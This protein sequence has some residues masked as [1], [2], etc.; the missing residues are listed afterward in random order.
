MI[1][2]LLSSISAQE[3]SQVRENFAALG[4]KPTEVK[5]QGGHYLVGLENGQESEERLRNMPGVKKVHRVGESYQLVSRKWKQHPT[6]IEVGSDLLI[7]AD[8]LTVIAGPCAIESEEQI[9]STLKHLKQNGVSLMRGGVF[10]PRTS[11]YSFRG[12]GLEGLELWSA[13]ARKEGIRVVSEVLSPDQ[14]ELMLPYVDMFQVGARNSQ[15]FSLLHELG[16]VDRPVL[17]KRGLSGTLDELL[18]SAEYVFSGGNEKIILCERGIRTYETSYRNTL[19]LNAIPVLKE[20]THLPVFVD[21]SHGIGI[22]RHIEAVALAAVMAGADGLMYEVHESPDQAL[23]DAQQT[24][25]FDES[26][27]MLSRIRAAAQLRDTWR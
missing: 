16:R 21:P 26:K 20:K 4:L 3:L 9:R 12:V 19:D 14:V 15:N 24:L 8:A 2:E 22:R 18:Q 1:V 7:R 13:L 6:E 10:K 5:T 27:R 11:P 25:G 17:L 23:S